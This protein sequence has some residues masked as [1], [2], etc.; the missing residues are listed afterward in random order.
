M[1]YFGGVA[2]DPRTS[3]LTESLVAFGGTLS[4]AGVVPL[5][6]ELRSRSAA[7]FCRVSGLAALEAPRG[8]FGNGRFGGAAAVAAPPGR[9]C[10]GGCSRYSL[11]AGIPD[12]G[13]TYAARPRRYASGP[14]GR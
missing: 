7:Q 2:G 3:P 1:G 4:A 14:T 9:G 11:T 10:G 8:G 5:A 13:K 12:C 6:A